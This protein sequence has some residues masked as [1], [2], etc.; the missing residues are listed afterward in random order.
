MHIYRDVLS[1]QNMLASCKKLPYLI[2]VAHASREQRHMLLHRIGTFLRDRL[3]GEL[4]W[5]DGASLDA[6]QEELLAPSLFKSQNVFALEIE[7]RLT[8]DL[9]KMIASYLATPPT[10]AILLFSIETLKG[11]A[12]TSLVALDLSQE[13]KREQKQRL[14]REILAMLK[15]CQKRMSS[16]AIHKLLQN[17]EEEM[18]LATE[19]DKLIAYV[20]DRQEITE[21]D[22]QE[23]GFKV[24]QEPGWSQM[25]ALLWEGVF[26]DVDI[27]QPTLMSLLGLLRF[28]VQQAQ[29][30]FCCIAERKSQEEIF[31]FCKINSYALSELS[32]RFSLKAVSYMQT[33]ADLIYETELLLKDSS[34]SP[35][36]IW[37]TFCLHLL[38]KR[39]ASL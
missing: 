34:I 28:L 5:Y 2:G 4:L 19:L 25:K 30:V 14:E 8:K 22:I 6:M 26:V 1:L 20:R 36:W 15:S 33:A 18:L 27:D 13:T 7:G 23:I 31:R 12:Q 3:H 32:Q 29:K 11:I 17:N 16:Q 10:Q 9:Q 37:Q 21:Q 24:K 38:A 39:K 35:K